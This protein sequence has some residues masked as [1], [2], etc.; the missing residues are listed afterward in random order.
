[1]FLGSAHVGML[2]A[3]QE[4]GIPIDL[5][6]GVSIGMS[7]HTFN[8]FVENSK[9]KKLYFRCFY[10]CSFCVGEKYNDCDTK[11]KGMVQGM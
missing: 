10:G 4:A 3:I 8:C 6:G 9:S 5:I 11:S 7:K 2:K 1:L